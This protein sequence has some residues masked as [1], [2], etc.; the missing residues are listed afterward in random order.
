M[1]TFVLVHGAWHG[2]WC[3]GPLVVQLQANG[4][5][6]IALELP[7]EDTQAT[8][9]DYGRLIAQATPPED[10]VLVA[11]SLGGASAVLAAALQPPSRLIYLGAL[12]AD[13]GRSMADQYRDDRPL[14]PGATAAVG[15]IGD[16]LSGWQDEDAAIEILYHDCEPALGRW[17]VAHLSGQSQTPQREPC[18]LEHLPDVPTTYVICTDDRIVSPEWSRRAATERLGVEPIE[19]GGGHS[20]MLARPAELAALLVDLA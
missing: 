8:F 12:L 7:I 2:A 13:P 20:P 6:A 1:A 4:H 17:A 3:W 14:V 16:G 19:I 9:S 15:P 18:P 10:A 11:H 5:E